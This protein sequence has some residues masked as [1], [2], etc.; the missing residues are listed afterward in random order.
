MRTTRIAIYVAV[1][2]GI[3]VVMTF[4]A[5][6]VI[7][8]RVRADVESTFDKVLAE[9]DKTFHEARRSNAPRSVFISSS[10]DQ[11]RSLAD[12]DKRALSSSYAFAYRS[13]FLGELKSS[14]HRHRGIACVMLGSSFDPELAPALA[15]LLDDATEVTWRYSNARPQVA[16][17][18]PWSRETVRDYARRS[19]EHQTGYSF[20]SEVAFRR[21]WTE[22]SENYRQKPWYWIA[23]WSFSGRHLSSPNAVKYNW[24]VVIGDEQIRELSHL[25]PDSALKILLMSAYL[26]LGI[27]GGSDVRPCGYVS[28]RYDTKAFARFV[29]TYSL[30]GKLISLLR[31]ESLYPEI[32][33]DCRF[34]FFA[35]AVMRLAKD[36]FTDADEPAIAAAQRVHF[37][38]KPPVSD[39]VVFRSAIAP[40]RARSILVGAMRADPKMLILGHELIKVAGFSEPEMIL[41]AY[42]SGNDKEGYISELV[43]AVENHRPV[44]MW[45]IREFARELT[46]TDHPPYMLYVGA[47]NLHELCRAANLRSGKN[48]VAKADIA[49]LELRGVSY[50]KLPNEQDKLKMAEFEGWVHRNFERIK[51]ELLSSLKSAKVDG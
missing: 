44:S 26:P 51:R 19:L 1:L 8:H 29:R 9:R 24:E 48:L 31:Q 39:M 49:A 47:H 50:D 46:L 23:K 17:F 34:A 21:W 14:D 40:N 2:L 42:R 35:I 7:H 10:I 5:L 45:L 32:D 16:N 28:F 12:L 33:S 15:G 41:A 27:G 36:V 11:E 3:C 30:K 43:S 22:N 20:K 18:D 6:S 4:G 38:Y 37:P 13:A 25:K